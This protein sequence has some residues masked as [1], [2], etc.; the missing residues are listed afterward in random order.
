MV[1]WPRDWGIF[2]DRIKD[3][4]DM[5]TKLPMEELLPQFGSKMLAPANEQRARKLQNALQSMVEE[6]VRDGWNVEID[7]LRDAPLPGRSVVLVR[8]G[9]RRNITYGT[10]FGMSFMLLHDKLDEATNA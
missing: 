6:G 9:E 5:A 8:Q 2:E 1:V 4:K 3:I 7:E 10:M